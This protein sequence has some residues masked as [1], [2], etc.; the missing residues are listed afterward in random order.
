MARRTKRAPQNQGS[1]LFSNGN[2][3]DFVE[4]DKHIPAP[5]ETFTPRWVQHHLRPDDKSI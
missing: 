5:N 4:P 2:G 3:H 1:S